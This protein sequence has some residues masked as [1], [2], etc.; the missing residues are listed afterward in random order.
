VVNDWYLSA[1]EPLKDGFGKVVGMLY[2]GIL[3]RPFKD[4]ARSTGIRYGLLVLGVLCLALVIALVE[5]G[6]LA[7]PIHRLV[8]ASNQMRRGDRPVPVVPDG[9]CQE[10]DRLVQS[11]NEMVRT[12]AE[13]EERMKALNRSYMETLGFVSHELKSPVA[14]IM[15]YSYLLREEKLGPLTEKQAKAVRS[16]DG[17]GKRLVEMVRH[18]LNLSRIENAELNPVFSRVAVRPDVLDPVLE[19]LDPDLHAK[20]MVLSNEVP[21]DVLL[22]ADLNLV[23][24]VFENLIGNAIKYGRP[25]GRIRIGF[26]RVDGTVEFCVA[27]EGNGIPPD[28]VGSLFQK[29]SRIESAPSAKAQKGTGLGLFITKYIVEAHGGRISVKSVVNEWTEFTFTLPA[30]REEPAATA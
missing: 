25:G 15:N 20:G 5:A 26:R 14:T 3:K 7:N 8:E 18:Y 22:H 30:A 6:R 27:N 1:F 24:E 23:H 19:A 28:R 29:F 11:F 13:R 9:R 16:I 17:G 4:Y 12:L 2:V 10:T 21:G